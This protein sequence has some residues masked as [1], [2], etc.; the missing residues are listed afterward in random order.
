MSD[1]STARYFFRHRDVFDPDDPAARYVMRLSIALGDL[2]IVSKYATRRRQPNAERVYFVRLLASHLREIVV[3]MNPPDRRHVPGVEEFL[4]A[5][6]DDITPTKHQMRA[7]HADAVRRLELDMHPDRPPITVKRRGEAD[8][9]RHPRLLDDLKELRNRFFH[10]GHDESGDAA[11]RLAMERWSPNRTGYVI[12]KRSMRALYADQVAIALAHPFPIPLA[13]DMHEQL[14]GLLTPVLHYIH[15]VEAAW[16]N[17]NADGVE[18]R[19]NDLPRRRLSTFRT[20]TTG[21]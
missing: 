2:R 16:I 15:M 9:E 17:A 20:R 8:Q 18:V 19:F 11:L 13:H 3:L 10:Y 5:L 1:D 6:P 4:A 14:L 7:A 21:S 12:S